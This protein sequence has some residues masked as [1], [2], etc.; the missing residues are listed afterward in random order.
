MR[1]SGPR[2]FVASPTMP[3]IVLVLSEDE[4]VAT[5]KAQ[6]QGRVALYCQ[7]ATSCVAICLVNLFLPTKFSRDV[8]VGF[9]TFIYEGHELAHRV[10]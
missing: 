7:N 3:E 2:D 6:T 9:S 4:F 10:G 5:R 1:G 8:A